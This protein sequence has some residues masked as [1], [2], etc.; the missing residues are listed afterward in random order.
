MVRRF[1]KEEVEYA[2]EESDGNYWSALGIL[3]DLERAKMEELGITDYATYYK[4]IERESAEQEGEV[5]IDEEGD[6][7]EKEEPLK[8]RYL[9]FVKRDA[10]KMHYV[11]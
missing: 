7:E 11:L 8:A 1:A 6:G 2:L 5:W 10:R 4:M 3:A 9:A